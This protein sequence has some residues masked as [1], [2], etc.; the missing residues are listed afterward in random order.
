MFERN[1][2]SLK[3][4]LFKETDLQFLSEYIKC[5]KPIAEAIQS[6]QGENNIYYGILLP[7]LMRIVKILSSLKIENLKYCSHLIEVIDRNLK[8]RFKQFY[9]FESTANNAILA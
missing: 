2:E 5:L 1:T 9:L 7:E 3:L 6:L 4:P 8:L